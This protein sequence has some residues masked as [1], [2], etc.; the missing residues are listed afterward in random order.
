MQKGPGHGRSLRDCCCSNQYTR[1][2]KD[3]GSAVVVFGE[4]VT[5]EVTSRSRT[6][7]KKAPR[8]YYYYARRCRVSLF[9]LFRLVQRS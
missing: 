5:D 1:Q 6:R 7:R 3:V 9:A 8:Y 2:L 4:G